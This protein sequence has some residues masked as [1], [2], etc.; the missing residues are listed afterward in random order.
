MLEVHNTPWNET[1][2]QA[3]MNALSQEYQPL[4]DMRA[5][6]S[7]RQLEAANLLCRFFLETARTSGETLTQVRTGVL[8]GG[9][10]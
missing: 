3:T 4:S 10:A 5:T 7:Y 2:V 1:T 9:G 6:A 8:F